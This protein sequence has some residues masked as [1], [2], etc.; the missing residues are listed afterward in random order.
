VQTEELSVDYRGHWQ[1][2][3]EISE[4]S[5][6]VRVA[7]L[8]QALVIEAVS[9]GGGSR[10]VISSEKC[11]LVWVLEMITQQETHTLQGEVA[12]VDVVSQKEEALL[13][14]KAN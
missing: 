9:L 8:L 3:K 2:V 1:K 7:V 5:P 10:L 12:A 11:D 14:W 13:G 6:N 4:H